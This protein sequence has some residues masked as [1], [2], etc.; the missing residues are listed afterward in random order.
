MTGKEDDATLVDYFV[1][2]GYDP[3]SGLVTEHNGEGVWGSDSGPEAF[4]PPL[5]RSFV[6]KIIEYFP[7]KRRSCPF[8]P[9]VISLCMPKGL[10]FYTEKCVP[11][12]PQLHTFANIRE[13]GSRVNG[14]AIT[15]YEEVSD[16]AV[17]SAIAALQQEHVRKV[18]GADRNELS[19]EHIPPGTISGGTHTLPRGRRNVGKRISY[20]DGGG[21]DTL[22]MSK[23]LCLVSRLPIVGGMHTLLQM[24]YKLASDEGLSTLPVE[25]YVYWMLNEVPLPSPGTTLKLRLLDDIIVVQRPTVKELPFFDYPLT[26][27]FEI[28]SVEKVIRIW[29]AFLLEHQIIICSKDLSRLMLVSEALC[30]LSFPFRWQLTYV[31]ILP[32][33]Q[34]KFIEAPVPYVMGI[35][36][37]DGVPECLYQCNVCVLDMDSLRVEIPEDLPFFPDHKQLVVQIKNILVKYANEPSSI[38][39]ESAFGEEERT[40]MRMSRSFDYSEEPPRLDE[41]LH[42]N[43]A[44]AR[45][46][47]IARRAG[48]NYNIQLDSLKEE[49]NEKKWCIQSR[50]SRTYFHDMRANNAIRQCFASRM[51]AIFRSYEQFV[52]GNSLDKEDDNRDSVVSFDKAGFMADHKLSYLPFLAAFL[53]TQMFTSFIDAKLMHGIVSDDNVFLFDGMIAEMKGVE[54]VDLANAEPFRMESSDELIVRREEQLDYVVPPPHSLPCNLSKKKEGEIW[55]T[56]DATL[57]TINETMSPMP[58]PWKQR[59]ARLKPK[60]IETV[61]PISTYSTGG[62]TSDHSDHHNAKFVEQLLKETKGKTK[63][64]LVEKL[65]KEAV[66]LGHGEGVRGVE[67]NTLVASLCDLLERI[68]SHGHAKKHGKSS[69]WTILLSHEEADKMGPSRRSSSQS[70]LAPV[71]RRYPSGMVPLPSSPSTPSMTAL[72]R[73]RRTTS[74]L[75]PPPPAP[76]SSRLPPPSPPTR[77]APSSTLADVS[78]LLAGMDASDGDDWKSSLFKAANSLAERLANGLDGTGEKA[79]KTEERS[80]GIGGGVG[81]L[82][83][84]MKKS[85][86]FSDF[87]APSWSGDE[88]SRSARE[89]RRDTGRSRDGSRRRRSSSRNGSPEIHY[90]LG[91]LS[92]SVS[93]DLKNVLRMCEMKSE[94]G[95]AR[96]FVRLALER[97]L[98]H[99]HLQTIVSNER[100]MSD[101][102]KPYAFVRQEEEREQFLMHI[103]SLNAAKF[104]CFT[105]TFTKTRIDYQVVLS[106]GSWTGYIPPIW[107]MVYGSHGES[108]KMPIANT[109]K[110]FRFEH[111]NLGMLSSLRIG[112]GTDK[113]P[114][115]YLDN[116]M[117]RND[118]TGARYCFPCG[119]WFGRGV[120]DGGLERL[121]IANLMSDDGREGSTMESGVSQQP[122]STASPALRRGRTPHSRG[123][124]P[125]RDRSPSIGRTLQKC[126]MKAEE[127][128]EML[129]E[130]VNALIRH[131]DAYPE[132]HNTAEFVT[133]LHGSEGLIDTISVAFQC[134]RSD[135]WS[136]RL[137]RGIYP[138]DYIE[139]VSQW[140]GELTRNSAWKGLDLQRREMISYT[141]KLVHRINGKE[142]LGKESKFH[143]FVLV[144]I[145]DHSFCG[146]LS[147]M[148]WTPVTQSMYDNTSFIRNAYLLSRFV[149]YLSSLSHLNR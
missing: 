117:I 79:E 142:Q 51:A 106:T 65:G 47:E 129:G 108:T 49:L 60:T 17:C 8:S 144:A 109:T 114:K 141:L 104:R 87:T 55:R 119:R 16:P 25:S 52:L 24:I 139:K 111:C 42:N 90:T 29:T 120:D 26:A 149:I 18:T 81:M 56:L 35:C 75:L 115:W 85:P 21:H 33:A 15:F 132:G 91:P 80:D 7:K 118:M 143:V 69:L 94:L 23:T 122:P 113:P 37:E 13:D 127:I 3:E 93:Y 116:I 140:M 14:T 110:T 89:T 92:S 44:L 9:E 45:V 145:R 112:H 71:I 125:L 101:H 100:L 57:L 134:G 103:M 136:G 5:Q 146:L 64:M 107:L 128:E 97:R 34:L 53:E 58:S 137:L 148:A 12:R 11:Q 95:Y 138:W 147:L 68:F 130:V 4:R 6:P 121:L 74:S 30:A 84:R 28:I 43:S 62:I 126:T 40:G 131:L 54:D 46:A 2:T 124:T 99:K 105:N 39:S 77:P 67:E 20:Y 19:R 123:T 66:E 133:L 10:R 73:F 135:G 38:I 82:I 27:L 36:T 96:A 102:Y 88:G 72:P 22:Y 61:R 59:Y 78:N 41:L 32:S 70:Y 1:V 98:L 83:N 63:R 86:S 31:P 76:P 50:Q 48:V